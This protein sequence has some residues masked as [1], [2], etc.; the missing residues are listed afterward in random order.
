MDLQNKVAIV[1]GGSRGIGLAVVE[2][3]LKEGATV[4]LCGS[5]KETAQQAVDGIKA[6]DP[7][8]KVEGICPN[9]SDY[10]SVKE[11][12]DSVAK[13]Y[14]KID[15]LVNNAGVSENTPFLNYTEEVFERV[16]DLNVKGVYNCSKA[17]SDYMVK[18]GNG[19]ILNVSSMVSR[20]G[21]PA[22]IA[23]PTSKFAVNGFTLSLAR[24]LAPKGVRVNA[25]APGV[26][27]TDMVK[28]LP[29]QVIEPLINS[30]PLHRIGK[31]EDI[32]NALVFLASEKASYITGVVLSVD[33]LART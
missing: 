6:K 14:G 31:P 15:V 5:R 4:V 29:Q 10:A 27:E 20:Y 9:L 25:V 26:T 23:Y 16:M 11:A 2:A 32:A 1:T 21:Q 3:F 19:C 17:V 22:G 8:A 33:G 28:A 7:K 30:I 12:F 13:K 18:Q 24:E